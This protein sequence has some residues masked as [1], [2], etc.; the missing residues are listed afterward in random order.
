M[1]F[2]ILICQLILTLMT[3]T[4]DFKD[5]RL[6]AIKDEPVTVYPIELCDLELGALC[7]LACGGPLERVAEIWQRDLEIFTTEVCM[8]CLHIQRGWTPTELWQQAAAKRLDVPLKIDP[9]LETNRERAYR[10]RELNLRPLAKTRC[11]ERTALDV[12]AAFGAGAMALKEVGYEVEAVEADERRAQHLT[13][14]GI[15]VVGS[16][17]EGLLAAEPKSYGLVMMCHVL[18]H[19]HDPV[20]VL[21]NLPKLLAGDGVAY[22]EVPSRGIINWSDAFYL[23]HLSNFTSTSFVQMLQRAT[24]ELAVLRIGVFIH[25]GKRPDLGFVVGRGRGLRRPFY[26]KPSTCYVHQL[27]RTGLAK[28]L[29][30]EGVLRYQIP[31]VD[32]YNYGLRFNRYTAH[33]VGFQIEFTEDSNV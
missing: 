32:H 15:N 3:L 12:G 33:R 13:E 16:T 18:E 30:H 2:V 26:S 28:Q 5:Q 7:C 9:T 10:R 11:I 6:A 25:E 21:R 29:L 24:D 31:W 20:H 14:R 27:Y 17:L 8:A 4:R 22:I 1:R 19:C 23:A